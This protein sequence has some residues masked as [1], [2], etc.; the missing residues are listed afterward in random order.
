MKRVDNNDHMKRVDN[1]AAERPGP[2]LA[3]DRS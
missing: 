2:G 3:Q 1:T